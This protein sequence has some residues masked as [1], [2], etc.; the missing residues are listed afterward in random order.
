MD[1]ANKCEKLRIKTSSILFYL[2]K[3]KKTMENSQ[4]KHVE[5]SRDLRYG[6]AGV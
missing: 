5:G 3:S 4:R 2:L 1:W 6:I